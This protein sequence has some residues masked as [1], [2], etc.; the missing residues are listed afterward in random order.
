M[1]STQVVTISRIR[2]RTDACMHERGS[3]TSG[4]QRRHACTRAICC[5]RCPVHQPVY[6]RGVGVGRY[7][8]KTGVVAT[9]V[10][11]KGSGGG[12]VGEE[13]ERWR[14]GVPCACRLVSRILADPP[15]LRL[16]ACPR[17]AHHRHSAP[18]PARLAGAP[19]LAGLPA[20]K[21]LQ[22]GL[23]QRRRSQRAATCCRRC[24]RGP[25]S[26][27]R[28]ATLRAA[29]A[30]QCFTFCLQHPP[31]PPPPMLSVLLP[32]PAAHLRRWASRPPAYRR[33]PPGP[34]L[35]LRFLATVATHSGTF[36]CDEALATA[37]LRRHPRFAQLA[38]TRTRDP[39]LVRQ[40]DVVLD[41]GGIYDPVSLRFDHHQRSFVSTFDEQHT[42]RLS[43]AGLVWKY[44]HLPSTICHQPCAMCRLQPAI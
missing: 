25:T 12:R 30:D 26:L 27:F 42:V 16:S 1:V 14:S 7:A 40:A 13:G 43:S 36:H 15:A 32:M 21:R 41:V 23:P 17:T 20:Y 35:P 10:A 9:M 33:G 19:T 28:P 37:L 22:R 4:R 31:P 44:V 8:P 38:L 2:T 3:T 29:P 6:G 11:S 24:C 34:L 39:A 18:L 5:A